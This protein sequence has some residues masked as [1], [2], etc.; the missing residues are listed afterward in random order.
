MPFF[1]LR[2]EGWL[3]GLLR[4]DVHSGGDDDATG[5]VDSVPATRE[6]RA[7]K[8]PPFA[9]RVGIP[10]ANRA[11]SCALH[12]ASNRPR[13]LLPKSLGY[14]WLLV[15][16]H[17]EARSCRILCGQRAR[18]TTK[19][20]IVISRRPFVA[21]FLNWCRGRSLSSDSGVQWYPWTTTQGCRIKSRKC[22]LCQ[23]RRRRC[24]HHPVNNLRWFWIR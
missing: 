21:P 16:F 20:R 9:R 24:Q 5:A 13:C 22:R 7:A 4:I 11:P 17:C 2:S 6:E 18:A 19:V 12:A 3:G 15:M 14:R 23:Y 8:G 10:S 1:R